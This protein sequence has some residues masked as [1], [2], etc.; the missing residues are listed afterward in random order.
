[1][2]TTVRAHLAASSVR[3]PS[4]PHPKMKIGLGSDEGDDGECPRPSG[5]CS[6]LRPISTRIA[7]EV[8]RT[9]DWIHDAGED[10]YRRH[11]RRTDRDVPRPHLAPRACGFADAHPAAN[12]GAIESE[13]VL[14]RVLVQVVQWVRNSAASCRACRRTSGRPSRP[15]AS[16]R[17]RRSR[18][19]VIDTPPDGVQVRYGRRATGG[20][21]TDE[22]S[23]HSG[24]C[25]RGRAVDPILSE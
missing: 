16:W 9:G 19:G 12:R 15:R 20:E 8:L 5:Y 23:K 14:E 4:A 13:A 24:S 6:A 22:T 1:M 3:Y 7:R 18:S 2:P 21:E 10:A 17:A 25:G 11:S